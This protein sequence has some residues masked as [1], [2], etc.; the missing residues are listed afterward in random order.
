MQSDF[1]SFLGKM[2]GNCIYNESP[3]TLVITSL[4]SKKDA[5]YSNH[6][7]QVL[8]PMEVDWIDVSKLEDAM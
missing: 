3:Y 4:E 1:N 6:F 2:F 7:C 5:Y 8:T